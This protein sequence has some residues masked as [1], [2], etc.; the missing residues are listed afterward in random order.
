MYRP[1]AAGIGSYLAP[2]R[3][4]TSQ[5]RPRVRQEFVVV[6]AAREVR[7]RPADVG[8]DHREQ[9]RRGGREQADIQ[10]GIQHKC[11]HIGAVEDVL[12][13]P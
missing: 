11:R 12:K 4:V 3:R 8:G 1:P 7:K 13:V 10:V 5:H 6:E 9:R 2:D